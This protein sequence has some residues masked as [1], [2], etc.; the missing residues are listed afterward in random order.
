MTC[1]INIKVKCLFTR[2]LKLKREQSVF[3]LMHSPVAQPYAHRHPQFSD[4]HWNPSIL[5][6]RL[7]FPPVNHNDCAGD[8]LLCVFPLDSI[9][10]AAIFWLDIFYFPEIFRMASRTLD[11]LL[12]RGASLVTMEPSGATSTY[13]GK[14]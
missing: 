6:C 13:V 14:P 10:P 9:R 12:G 4:E 2:L 11:G 5:H 7:P 8:F 1:Y 3:L